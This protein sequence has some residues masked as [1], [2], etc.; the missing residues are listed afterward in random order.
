MI[1]LPTTL[2]SPFPLTKATWYGASR[3]FYSCHIE[4]TKCSGITP[5]HIMKLLQV[6]IV[7]KRVKINVKTFT[8]IS[9]GVLKEKWR[10]SISLR[11][12]KENW[13]N[14]QKMH[15]WK[16]PYISR[17]LTKLQKKTH[18]TLKRK[19]TELSIFVHISTFCLFG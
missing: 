10:N 7:R 9:L 17:K 5:K 6:I 3:F 8:S 19:N 12:L 11:F 16:E 13:G 15:Q 14:V 2:L 18:K 1:H 4:F